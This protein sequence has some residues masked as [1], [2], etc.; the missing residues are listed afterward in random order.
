MLCPRICAR[1]R[2]T[3]ASASSRGVQG[4]RALVLLG[5]FKWGAERKNR[6]FTRKSGIKIGCQCVDY[7]VAMCAGIT[8]GRKDQ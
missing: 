2:E 1:Q 3:S 8:R 5:K 6:Q 7:L 4:E